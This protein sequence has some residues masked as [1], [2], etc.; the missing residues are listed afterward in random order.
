VASESCALDLI[1]ASTEREIQ[2]GEVV[3][4]D[5][6]GR[7]DSFFL[8]RPVRPAFCSFE[9]IYF[10]RPDSKIF[11]REIYGLRKSMGRVLAREAPVE[12][13]VVI[14]VPDSGVPMAL[15]YSE[16]SGIPHELGLIRNHYVGRTFIE[17]SQSIRDFG[18]KLK[19]NPIESVL[20]GRRVVVV[21]DSI[22]RGTTSVK[23]I[24]MI[25]K[26]GAKEIHMRV[27]SP[28]IT[29][30]CFFGVD[31]P[32]RDQLM[33][34]QH[35][36]DEIRNII[37]ADSLGFLSIEGLREALGVTRE[38]DHFCYGCFTGQYPEDVG[39]EV[40]EQPTDATGG[41]G[42]VSYRYGDSARP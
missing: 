40:P 19:L 25:R 1:G 12:A 5:R 6:T 35:H 10:A 4:I 37:G 28:P 31:T 3:E 38:I 39:R 29:H 17:P 16:Q 14:A 30:S 8:A 15:G 26:A 42:L 20:A 7:V 27:G 13:D 32:E 23:I 21:D 2:P 34:A 41:P 9:P 36:I 22:V 11:N 33:A 18:V 24:R